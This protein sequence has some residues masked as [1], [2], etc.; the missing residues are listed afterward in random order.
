MVNA[1]ATNLKIQPP[2]PR[3]EPRSA[4]RVRRLFSLST[5]LDLLRLCRL[6]YALPLSFTLGLTIIYAHDGHIGR[7]W[8]GTIAASIALALVVAAGYVFN[9]VCDRRIDRINAPARPLAAGHV[10]IGIACLWAGLLAAA[11]LMIAWA[12]CRSSFTLLLGGVAAALFVYDLFSKRLGFGKQLLVA[13]L[14]TSIYPLAI[15]QAGSVRGWS[16]PVVPSR[17]ATL[18]F[19]PVWLFLTG[20]GY[21]ILKDIRDRHGD[22]LAARESMWIAAGPE[23]ARRIAAAAILLGT[24]VL[25]LPAGVGCGSLYRSIVPAAIIAGVVSTVLP[26]R[27]ALVALYVECVLVGVAATADLWS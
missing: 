14:M 24:L 27:S 7:Q 6:Y 5:A 8:G 22:Q 15:A 1:E 11:G 18:I 17:A 19:F 26:L 23:R 10:S 12:S 3:R 2:V 21:E 16:L 4:R 9:D 20:L 13:T 25:I